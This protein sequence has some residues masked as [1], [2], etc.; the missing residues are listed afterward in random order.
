MSAPARPTS[1]LP[2]RAELV[3][4]AFVVILMLLGLVGLGAV[5]GD[6][7]Y[8]V[9]GAFGVLLGLVI[10]FGAIRLR[11]PW[12]FVSLAVLLSY[13]LLAGAVALRGSGGGVLPDVTTI[14]ILADVVLNGWRQLISVVPPVG[15]AG[16]LL[17]LPYLIGL[18]GSVVSY[19]LARR[20][21]TSWAPLIPLIVVLVASILLGGLDPYSLLLQGVVYFLVASLY[22]V[23]RFRRAQQ[24]VFHGGRTRVLAPV[25][26]LAVAA[27]G[28]LALAPALAAPGSQ[29]RVVLRESL[30]PPFDPHGWVSPLA[31][32]RHWELPQTGLGDEELFRIV[33]APT[34][35]VRIATMDLYDGTVYNVAG[36]P[37]P[38][39]PGV[40]AGSSGW[41]QPV[42]P[43]FATDPATDGLPRETY[44][45]TVG[46]YEGIW[47]PTVG[48]PT[49]LQFDGP[50]KDELAATLRYNASTSSAV[51]GISAQPNTGGVIEGDSYTLDTAVRPVDA[52]PG[53][54]PVSPTLAA[55]P[56]ITSAGALNASVPAPTGP[57]LKELSDVATKLGGTSA[58]AYTR[59]TSIATNL[60]A[61]VLSHGQGKSE[62]PSVAGHSVGRLR[63]L[64]TAE[65]PWVG[66]AEQFAALMSLL[67]TS[68][69]KDTLPARVV[70]GVRQVDRS[71]VVKGSDVTAWVEV[72]IEGY[73]WVPFFP[74]PTDKNV[75]PKVTGKTNNVP[76]PP[77]PPVS[78]KLKTAV[79]G[80]SATDTERQ[81]AAA[82]EITGAS[83]PWVALMAK[84]GAVL[85]IPLVLL[86]IPIALLLYLK[87]RRRRR[88]QSSAATAERIAGGWDEVVDWARDT[89]RDLPGRSTRSETAGA[90]ALAEPPV[91]VVP[92]ATH[93]DRAAFA[94]EVPTDDDAAA[95]WADV[96]TARARLTD[97]LPRWRR[98]WAHIN[99]ASLR[100]GGGGDKG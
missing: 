5:Y 95:Y 25:A 54:G 87:R 71:G 98:W 62:P 76:D 52:A 61:M 57:V 79:A 80:Q 44:R 67:L 83:N 82:A 66:D 15:S 11:A 65:Q 84:F 93:A 55:D 39:R 20:V 1:W 14:R 72:G 56:A 27:L 70:V 60:S 41:F 35:V 30:V 23:L 22:L 31:Q 51:A 43:V 12:V 28:G 47:L 3:D 85:A 49:S 68:G 24:V 10:A 78:P 40:D 63:D 88:R 90:L 64:M 73:G 74:S 19:T 4:A 58:G 7:T 21:A 94:P 45:I 32:L 91:D 96:E 8:L 6:W 99:P 100:H 46:K 9:V 37:G 18:L 33:P 97:G 69:D 86:G 81:P 17:A 34:S 42:G 53:K 59:A 38:P 89:G 13:F 36:N 2:T 48:A 92:L 75:K 77:P 50:R 29:E 26:V 16:P